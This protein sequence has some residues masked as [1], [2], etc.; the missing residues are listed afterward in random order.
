[1]G[2]KYRY[3]SKTGNKKDVF[4]QEGGFA[5]PKAPL[6]TPVIL[7]RTALKDLTCLLFANIHRLGSCREPHLTGLVFSIYMDF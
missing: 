6:D 3:F 1:M 2:G 5:H 4:F 7:G